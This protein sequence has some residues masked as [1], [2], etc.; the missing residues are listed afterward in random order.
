MMQLNAEM[1][2]NSGHGAVR[3]Q[4]VGHTADQQ[5]VVNFWQQQAEGHWVN[6]GTT[7]QMASLSTL[8]NMMQR[9]YDAWAEASESNA[10]TVT[11]GRTL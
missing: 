8:Q 7:K 2:V 5:N 4:W 6:L 11:H 9:M 10:F 3:Y 1:S